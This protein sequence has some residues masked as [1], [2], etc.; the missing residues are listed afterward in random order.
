MSYSN[1]Q[2]NA[3]IA[4]SD[5]YM[6][7]G[8]GTYNGGYDVGYICSNQHGKI[9]KW[10]KYKPIRFPKIEELIDSEFKGTTIDQING[11][12]YGLYGKVSATNYKDLH[13]ITYEYIGKPIGG[14]NEPFRLTDFIGYDHNAKCNLNGT[15]EKDG[16]TIYYDTQYPISLYVEYDH[17]GTNTTGINLSDF[18]DNNDSLD[19]EDYYPC[20]MIDNY[21]KALINSQLSEASMADKYTPIFSNGAYYTRFKTSI[22]L[23]ALK[24]EADRKVS[25]FL[26][27]K[28]NDNLINLTDWVDVTDKVFLN[29]LVAI[30]EATGLTYHFKPY[31]VMY[32][33]IATSCRA[34]TNG[35]SIGWEWEED[36]HP[37]ES[38]EVTFR[39][40][41]GDVLGTKTVT[42]TPPT[43]GLTPL[44]YVPFT[45]SEV[46]FVPLPGQSVN[47]AGYITPGGRTFDFNIT[48]T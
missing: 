30:P 4:A 27:K 6:V 36:K 37:T 28:I 24:V 17:L 1:G 7:L 23:P 40:D 3:P 20:I 2:I 19:I 10:A 18:T 46:G 15:T 8:V 5:P 43:G 11:I 35:F 16:S 39:L 29:P 9:N 33:A 42:Y 48:A 38:T 45:W 21:A 14:D 47:I 31:N 41:R 22:D 26:I 12:V 34:T 44:L 32:Y 25:F 13:N